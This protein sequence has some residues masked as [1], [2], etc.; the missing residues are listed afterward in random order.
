MVGSATNCTTGI[1]VRA[2]RTLS[3]NRNTDDDRCNPMPRG[4]GSAPQTMLE[5][6]EGLDVNI[7][8]FSFDCVIMANT[9]TKEK[10]GA[11]EHCTHMR[12]K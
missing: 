9:R 1:L 8:D 2:Y 11:S 12:V 7:I 4:S 6:V 5:P 3:R 10:A